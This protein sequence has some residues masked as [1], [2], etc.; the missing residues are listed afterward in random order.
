VID[1]PRY[2]RQMLLAEIGEEGQQRLE[3][4]TAELAGDGLLHEIAATYAAR[5]GIGRVVPGEVAS[6][7]APSFLENPAARAMVAG[8]RAAL[9]AMRSALARPLAPLQG[10]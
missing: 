1:R 2:V 8:S 9:L 4:A 7:L 10:S 5:A 3:V 6:S